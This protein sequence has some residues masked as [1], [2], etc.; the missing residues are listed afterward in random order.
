MNCNWA[1]HAE[2]QAYRAQVQ[3]HETHI[4]TRDARI[5]SLENLVATLVAQTSSLQTQLTTALGRI[6][7]LKAKEPTRTDDPED[8]GNSF[9]YL[10]KMPPKRTAATTT[11]MTDAQIKALISQ[12]VADALAEIK[13][14]RTSR[15]GDDSHD[16]R[17]GSGRR[18]WFEKMESVFHISNYTVAR[19]IKFATC[20]LQ[21]NAL[22]W[23]NS[24]VRTVGY[25][26]AYAM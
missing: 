12:G 17:T 6:Q 21:E 2:L 8:V 24:H 14:N 5:G 1:V 19:Q 3:I 4:Q 7:T 23:W 13:A 9:V 16:S 22:T 25:D 20:T 10:A 11:P 15:N 26:V 18:Q